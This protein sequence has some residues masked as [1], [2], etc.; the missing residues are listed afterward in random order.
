MI[1]TGAAIFYTS[2]THI[3]AS[4][5]TNNPCKYQGGQQNSRE[6]QGYHQKLTEKTGLS[7]KTHVKDR[8]VTKNTCF[9]GHASATTSRKSATTPQQI[10]L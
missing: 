3:P 9:F 2:H 6:V 5:Q 10:V 4:Q 7:P 8:V 1:V